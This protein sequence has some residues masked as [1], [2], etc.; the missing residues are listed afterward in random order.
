MS[1]AREQSDAAFLIGYLDGLVH[2]DTGTS[3]IAF[4]RCDQAMLRAA[5]RMLARG[6]DVAHLVDAISEHDDGEG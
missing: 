3:S 5:A 1:R 4:N 2:R 6:Y